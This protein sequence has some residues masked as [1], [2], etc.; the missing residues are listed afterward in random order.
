MKE[1]ILADT[2]IFHGM[3][4]NLMSRSTASNWLTLRIL[5]PTRVVKDKCLHPMASIP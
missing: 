3:S 4:E 5:C 1:I 2:Q